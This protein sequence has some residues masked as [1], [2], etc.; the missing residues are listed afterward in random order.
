MSESQ[1]SNAWDSNPAAQKLR[2]GNRVAAVVTRE[3]ECQRDG[4]PELGTR[5]LP[6]LKVETR[7]PYDHG[8]D[9]R[10]DMC[11]SHNP[12][13]VGFEPRCAE[14]ASKSEPCDRG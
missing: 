5:T 13:S 8:S 7:E 14:T 12:E 3:D 1:S 4:P 9:R 2:I 6:E 11:R 10:E